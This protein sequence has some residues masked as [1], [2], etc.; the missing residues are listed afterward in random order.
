[1]QQDCIVSSKNV[2]NCSCID[3]FDTA[4]S[5]FYVS[6]LSQKKL[7]EANLANGMQEASKGLLGETDANPTLG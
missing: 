2:S 1:V 5:H 6:C 4:S 7:H 3:R